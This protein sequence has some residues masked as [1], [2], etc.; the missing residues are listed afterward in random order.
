MKQI[1]DIEDLPSTSVEPSNDDLIILTVKSSKTKSKQYVMKYSDFKTRILADISDGAFTYDTINE[2]TA[3]SGVTVD[4]VILKDTTVDVNGTADAIILDADGDTTISSPTDDQIDFEIAG[5]D[6]F[7]MIANIFRALSGSVVETDTVNET[8]AGSG[9]TIDSALIKDGT[10]LTAVGAVGTP[11]VQVGSADTGLY[12]VS[13]TQTGIAQDG[14]L[15]AVIDSEGIKPDSVRH[16]VNLGTTPVG[17]V[18]IVEYGDGKDVTTV[19]T[20]TNFIV[21]ALAGAG[22]ALGLGNIVYAFP[23]GQHLELVSSLSDIVLTAAGTTVS[24]DTGLGSVIASGAV[25]TLDGTPEFEDRLTGQTISAEAAG[26][27]AVSA[28]TAATAGIG[29]G[30]S[31][32]VAGSVKN[33][34]LNSAG[35]WNADNTG[36]LTATGVI[37]LKWTKMS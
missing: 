32:N 6:D 18:D 15:V 30:I 21:G 23:A 7:R 33:V 8:T 4:G 3:G 37:I 19:L 5:A 27:A 11:A 10:I 28:L 13:A 31:L 12:Q 25:S 26:G 35:T 14:A 34:F 22:A 29:T 2:L 36:N 16:R 1:F 17:T 20:L 24:T 9:V